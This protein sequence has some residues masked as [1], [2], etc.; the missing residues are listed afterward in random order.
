MSTDPH[1]PGLTWRKSSRSGGAQQCVEVAP[2]ATGVYLRHSKR[3]SDGTIYFPEAD[4][5]AFVDDICDISTTPQNTT[6]RITVGLAVTYI[7]AM[8]HAI[9]LEFT[10]GEW[11]AFVE[12]ALD[13]EFSFEGMREA[14]KL[15]TH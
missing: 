10:R 6:A 11:R 13:G 15:R 3:P 4:W 2:S 8:R 1:P 12:G 14:A 7:Q 5:A 9:G